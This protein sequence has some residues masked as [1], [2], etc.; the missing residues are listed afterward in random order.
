MYFLG[1]CF[2]F[3]MSAFIQHMFLDIYPE[4]AGFRCGDTI[5]NKTDR[6]PLPSWNLQPKSL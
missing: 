3:C 1:C 2:F 6:K 5:M 4:P